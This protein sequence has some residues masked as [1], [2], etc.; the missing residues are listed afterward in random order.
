MPAKI[1]SPFMEGIPSKIYWALYVKP[2][3]GY[4]LAKIVYGK[5][6]N[7]STAKI[8]QNLRK[9]ENQGFIIKNEKNVYSVNIEPLIT[10]LEGILKIHHKKLDDSIKFYLRCTLES[11]LFKKVFS[12]WCNPS[13]LSKI[14]YNQVHFGDNLTGLLSL[15][16]SVVQTRIHEGKIE[17]D[18]LTDLYREIIQD[19]EDEFLEKISKP[20]TKKKVFERLV[21]CFDFFSNDPKFI[22]SYEIW[23]KEILDGLQEGFQSYQDLQES[24]Q[25]KFNGH[26]SSSEETDFESYLWI[27]LC[28][29]IPKQVLDTMVSLNPQGSTVV[30]MFDTVSK[31]NQAVEESDQK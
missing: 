11:E 5:K 6:K 29:W 2:V 20:F 15:Y 8:Y 10:Y 22:K 18:S 24:I 19:Y 26:Y 21:K 12:H 14:P 1:E 9:L 30:S 25:K 3:N 17:P 16:A 27:L 28:T 4:E 7:P 31:I 13:I 23:D